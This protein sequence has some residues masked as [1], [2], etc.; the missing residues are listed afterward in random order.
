MAS[1]FIAEIPKLQFYL[2]IQRDDR[3]TTKKV[4]T[5]V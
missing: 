2:G 4:I 5:D 1:Y 3:S